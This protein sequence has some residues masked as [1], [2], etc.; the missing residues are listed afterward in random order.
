MLGKVKSGGVAECHGVGSASVS[1]CRAMTA[2]GCISWWV[3]VV[4]VRR[5]EELVVYVVSDVVW[6]VGYSI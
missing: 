5:V 6:R 1:L 2:L 3:F 4:H